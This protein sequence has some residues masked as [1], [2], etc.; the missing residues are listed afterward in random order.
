MVLAV[1]DLVFR[2]VQLLLGVC[3][4][5]LGVIDLGLGLVDL[6]AAFFVNRVSAGFGLGSASRFVSV[7]LCSETRSR[8]VA[9]QNSRPIEFAAAC[10]RL[11]HIEVGN[12]FAGIHKA[13]HGE[14]GALQYGIAGNIRL[15]GDL[16][17]AVD[18]VFVLLRRIKAI[19]FAA[20]G[21]R[22][23]DTAKVETESGL[24]NT[25]RL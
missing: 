7:A 18:G 11:A 24:E 20:L 2:V 22:P 5:L 13:H 17:G 9:L 16:D 12:R 8:Y 25:R 19:S 4:L 10:G 3:Q 23:S 6:P 1:F 21:R 15:L 14:L